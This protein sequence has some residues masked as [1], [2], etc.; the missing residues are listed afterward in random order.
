M[1]KILI[2]IISCI[3]FQIINANPIKIVAA[4]NFYGKLAMEIGGKAVVVK[5]IINNPDSDPHL[6]TTSTAISKNL[7]NA[8][9]VIYNSADY[10]PWMEQILSS[11]SN[12]KIII[13][14]VAHLMKIKQG[15][16]P[17][18]W[19][20]PDTFPTL[21]KVIAK[22]VITLD[23]KN[24][25]QVEQNLAKFLIA[26]QIIRTK[27]NNIRKLN[28]GINV[29]AT[30]P[31]FNY[32]ATAMGFTMYGIDFQWKIMNDTEPSP[33]MLAAYEKLITKHQ[34]KILFYNKQV[35]GA[36]AKNMLQLAKH[37]K[38]AIVGITE[39][40]PNDVTINQWLLSAINDTEAALR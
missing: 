13:I 31:V 8:Q 22:A 21:A 39:T 19:Y 16:N 26:N 11:L 36:I 5:S 38:I 10:D 27:I 25:M 2:L 33:Q 28:K 32:M 23:K 12:K 4:E 35:T 34:V 6:F 9:I 30:E 14:N 15:A 20:Q 17:H 3:L 7:A 37:N 18:I 40:M 29:T 24:T 1:F